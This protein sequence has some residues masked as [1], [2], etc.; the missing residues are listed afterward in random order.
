MPDGSIVSGAFVLE[1]YIPT[2]TG[3]RMRRGSDPSPRSATAA[4]DIASMFAY[5]NGNN[6]K[7]FAATA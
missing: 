3:A 6:Q 1:N 2:A 7:L 5:V 4:Q